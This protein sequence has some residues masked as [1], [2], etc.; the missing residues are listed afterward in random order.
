MRDAQLEAER[1]ERPG[2]GH[3]AAQLEVGT[4]AQ[5][6]PVHFSFAENDHIEGSLSAE[7]RL[8]LRDRFDLPDLAELLGA[9]RHERAT[10][11]LTPFVE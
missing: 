8:L 3:Q 9:L 7:R 1:L 4:S 2:T 10:G 6:I 11:A 5:P